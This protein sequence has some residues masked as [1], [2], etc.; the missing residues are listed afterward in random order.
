M[1]YSI[2]KTAIIFLEILLVLFCIQIMFMTQ[3]K[4]ASQYSENLINVAA[5]FTFPGTGIIRKQ[6][7]ARKDFP[8]MKLLFL[9]APSLFA[10]YKREQLLNDFDSFVDTDRTKL[11]IETDIKAADRTDPRKDDNKALHETYYN[12][13]GWE[14]LAW[15][16]LSLN[17]L[18]ISI[19]E[20]KRNPKSDN[21]EIYKFALA[22]LRIDHWGTNWRFWIPV[23]W[24]IIGAATSSSQDYDIYTGGGLT[25]GELYGLELP[26]TY[27]S[28]I[29]EE[30]FFRGTVQR[31]IYETLDGM[32]NWGN[33]TNYFTSLVSGATVFGL[34]HNGL[35]GSANPLTAFIMGLYFGY[36]AYPSPSNPLQEDL[37]TSMA[38]HSWYDMIVTIGQYAHSKIHVNDKA[39]A[40]REV[41][42]HQVQCREKGDIDGKTVYP[43]LKVGFHY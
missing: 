8:F 30:L 11:I 22:P 43:L 39:I 42:N 31:G 29:A 24:G 4:A 38:A 25:K 13:Q 37:I 26:N 3:A 27:M 1:Q 10:F 5:E 35:Q 9:S 12:K 41:T 7:A 17:L 36:M 19:A 23:A 16:R 32:N 18:L 20:V 14:G 21:S 40:C 15:Q 2:R 6:A 33:R 28:G 34:S